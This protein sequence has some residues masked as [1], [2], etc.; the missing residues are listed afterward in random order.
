MCTKEVGFSLA[1]DP[2]V[3]KYCGPRAGTTQ[4][5]STESI[6]L[7]RLVGVARG[8]LRRGAR[9]E[10]NR[11]MAGSDCRSTFVTKLGNFVRS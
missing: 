5:A 11:L 9:L 7:R 3:K 8:Q 6:S 10:G 1:T 2:T 4:S